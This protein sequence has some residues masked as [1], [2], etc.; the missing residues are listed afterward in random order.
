MPTGREVTLVLTTAEGDVV[1]QLA[2]FPVATPW[3]SEVR[4]VVDGARERHG[5]EV[6]VLRLLGVH[7]HDNPSGMGQRV[8]YLAELHGGHPAGLEAWDG[9]IDDDP[10]RARWARPGGPA[11]DLAWADEQ[12]SGLGRLR[13]GPAV[14]HRTWNLSSLWTLPTAGGDVWL[15]AVPPL[16][17]HEGPVLEALHRQHAPV[18]PLLAFDDEGRVL[19]EHVEGENQYFAP[20]DRL[21]QMTATLVDLQTAWA[22]ERSPSGLRDWRRPAFTTAAIEVVSRNASQLSTPTRLGLDRLLDRMDDRFT[23]LEACGLPDT[24][25]HGDFHPGNFRWGHN[26]LVLLDWGD[27]GFGHP[28]LDL[29][30]FFERVPPEHRAAIEEGWL[31]RWAT[32]VPGS[33]P[34]HAADLIAPLAALR[35]AIVYQWFLDAIEPSEQRYHL[36]DV[37]RWLTAAALSTPPAQ[38]R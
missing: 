29:P 31:A 35:Q 27:S 24:L 21:R 11:A 1:G 15:K 6:T 38:V 18:P 32:A 23:A 16:L 19:L 13:T 26:L 3:W 5:V 7:P 14:Q 10:R 33:D 12:L 22:V 36:A 4:T 9:T 20:P 8:T 28:L 34:H 30:A 25:V 37:P 2:P 17:A